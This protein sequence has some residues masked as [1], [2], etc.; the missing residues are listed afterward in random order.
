MKTY[1]EFL[2]EVKYTTLNSGYNLLK[3]PSSKELFGMD[4]KSGNI[5][6]WNNMSRMMTHKNGDVYLFN[7]MEHTHHD[8]STELD[9]EGI[10]L[11]HSNPYHNFHLLHDPK[12]NIVHIF[13]HN[14]DNKENTKKYFDHNYNSSKHLKRSLENKKI[15]IGSGDD[16]FE[17]ALFVAQNHDKSVADESR[18]HL[19]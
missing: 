7:N 16:E 12:E 15:R 2:L 4:G 13:S 18:N 10:N 1:K 14:F 8:V 17:H 6:K 9:K 19:K 3:N 5:S 11:E